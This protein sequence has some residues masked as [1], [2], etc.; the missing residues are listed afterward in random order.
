VSERLL[1][2]GQGIHEFATEGGDVWDHAAPDQVGSAR[3]TL[4]D[5]SE[6]PSQAVPRDSLL[7]AGVLTGVGCEVP[8]KV[9]ALEV[10]A[11]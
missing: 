6:A 8:E 2:L 3:K 4:V 11:L 9:K 5:A 1:H 10:A 7:L